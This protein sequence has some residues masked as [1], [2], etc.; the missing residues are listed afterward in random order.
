MP[1]VEWGDFMPDIGPTHFCDELAAN[2]Q[3]A[4]AFIRL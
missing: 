3:M 1:H 2:M 4:L